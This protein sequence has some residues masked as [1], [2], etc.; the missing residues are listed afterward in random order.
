MQSDNLNQHMEQHEKKKYKSETF[1]STNIT[2]T[3]ITS[4]ILSLDKVGDFCL[5]RSTKTYEVYPLEREKMTKR[6]IKDNEEY[7]YSVARGKN[8]YEEVNKDGI[9]EESL[10]SEDKDLLEI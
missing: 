6:L 2:S 9:K 3:S 5:G 4:S 8:I 7:K 1:C 10:C